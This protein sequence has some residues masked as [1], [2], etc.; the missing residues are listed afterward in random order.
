[1]FYVSNETFS[2]GIDLLSIIF[3]TMPPNS[4]YISLPECAI[5]V[6]GLAISCY[7]RK[8]I[9]ARNFREM[10]APFSGAF[11]RTAEPAPAWPKC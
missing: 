7:G 3:E 5:P 1:M 6:L 9:T 8:N 2:E 4:I 10:E 11:L